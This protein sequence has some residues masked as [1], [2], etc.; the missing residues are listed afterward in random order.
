[1]CDITVM[2]PSLADFNLRYG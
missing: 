1:M 2:T